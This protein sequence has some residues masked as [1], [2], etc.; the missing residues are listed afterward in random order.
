[1]TRALEPHKPTT[2]LIRVKGTLDPSWSE[3]FDGMVVEATVDGNTLLTGPIRDQTALH[4]LLGKIRDMGL[5]LLSVE[6][7]NRRTKMK[8]D[9]VDRIVR[10]ISAISM[11]VAPVAT[12]VAF[13]IHPQFWTFKKESSAAIQFEYIQ[14]WGWQVGHMLVYLTIPLVI[15]MWLMVARK[16]SVRHPGLAVA[17]GFLSLFGWQFL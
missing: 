11:I 17:G 16:L 2:Y 9:K 14:T 8:T 3:W 1:M 4:G 13:A 7:L 15:I 6:Q 10:L 5:P 12:M